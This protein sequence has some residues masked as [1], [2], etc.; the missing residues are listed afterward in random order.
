MSILNDIRSGIGHLLTSIPSPPSSPSSALN[1][2]TH[3]LQNNP[4]SATA[5]LNANKN[6]APVTA[7]TVGMVSHPTIGSTPS[8]SS[9]KNSSTATTCPRSANSNKKTAM[10]NPSS[11]GCIKPSS[12]TTPA[13]TSLNAPLHPPHL[14]HAGIIT[15]PNQGAAPPSFHQAHAGIITSPNQGA[16]PSNFHPAH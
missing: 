3:T 12:S 11:T 14:A 9:A 5:V 15:S 8:A 10:P 16:A 2:A 4:A 7:P 1:I 6:I 13:S